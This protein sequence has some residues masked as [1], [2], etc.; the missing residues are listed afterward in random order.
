MTVFQSQRNFIS[1]VTSYQQYLGL[2]GN[3]YDDTMRQVGFIIEI[4]DAIFILVSILIVHL[5]VGAIADIMG[6]MIKDTLAGIM[7]AIPDFA[8][9]I[10][11]AETGNETF[12]LFAQ[13]RWVAYIAFTIFII[14]GVTLHV[15]T[16]DRQY[17]DLIKTSVFSII[18]IVS[19]PII[20]DVAAES[21]ENVTMY[22]LNPLYSF[23][24]TA[25][26][27]DSYTEQQIWDLYNDSPFSRGDTVWGLGPWDTEKAQIVCTPQYKINYVISQMSE[28]QYYTATTD[29]PYEWFLWQIGQFQSDVI[30][31]VFF[32]MIQSI[33]IIQIGLLSVIVAIMTDLLTAMI[34]AA[35]PI[36]LVLRVIPFC[37][38]TVD[39]FLTALPALYLIPIMSAVII[40]VGAGVVASAGTTPIAGENLGGLDM[41]KIYVWVAALGVTIF[42]VYLPVIMVSL[43]SDV[44]G[45]ATR[46]V[47]SA[48]QAATVITAQAGMGAAKGIAGGGRIKGG[49]AGAGSG[50]ISGMGGGSKDSEDDSE[51]TEDDEER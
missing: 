13:F 24:S 44:V 29:N 42:A 12:E 50:I 28:G 18:V 27:P 7:I 37:K 39:K 31:Q 40:T 19:F 23:D 2:I 3:V 5:A 34:I 4:I 6:T 20:W 25:P 38:G 47:T 9:S 51:D 8:Y 43:L 46:M 48:V 45:Q 22:M 41:A 35:F 26:C 21:M 10:H 32:S 17:I 1:N 15:V 30:S 14:V 33:V 49:L 16:K 36:L 11:G